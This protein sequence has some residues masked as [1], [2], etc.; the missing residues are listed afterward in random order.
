MKKLFLL[1]LLFYA[2]GSF[3]QQGLQMEFSEPDSAEM[4]LQRQIE[5][6]QLISGLSSFLN[7]DLSLPDMNYNEEFSKRY[8]ISF[9]FLPLN[10]Y[11]FGGFASGMWGTFNSPFFRNGTI[12]SSAAYQLGDKFTLGGFSYG[13]SSIMSAPH[14]NQ[15][16]NHFDSYGST[17][18]MQYKVSKNFK[19]ETRVNV[20]QGGYPPGF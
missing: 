2:L 8:T 16:L 7:E 12:L 20:S 19:I 9:E 14:P 6:H 10:S 13:A 1:L 15:G 4:R 3:A 11:N 5:Y 17:L 18:F